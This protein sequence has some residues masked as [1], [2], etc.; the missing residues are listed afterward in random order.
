MNK[1]MA[2][3][4][5]VAAVAGTLICVVSGVARILG[6]YDVAGVDSIALFTVG[7]GVMVFACLAKLHLLTLP[8][9]GG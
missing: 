2:I 6:I 3:A 7:I 4:G 9:K 1:L 5:T 8:T